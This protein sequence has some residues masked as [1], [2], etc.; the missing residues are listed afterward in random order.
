[1]H[2]PNDQQTDKLLGVINLKSPFGVR[3]HRMIQLALHTGLR[4]SEQSGLNVGHV[5]RHGQPREVLDLS[6]VIAKL[7]KARL[8]PLNDTAKQVIA[9]LLAFNQSRGLS[10]DPDAPLLQNR[11][12][13]RLTVR[14][15]QRLVA[16]Y[17]E[18]AELD[19]K[20]TPHSFRHLFASNVLRATNNLRLIKDLVGHKDIRTTDHY[21]HPGLDELIKAV[22]AIVRP[23]ALSR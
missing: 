14:A 23:S 2:I 10:I 8:I 13:Q 15:I 1:M 18:V 20:V 12:H 21:C 6:P 4:V 9:E 3:D 5:T 16:Y 17:R 19:V 22:A 7:H 11:K